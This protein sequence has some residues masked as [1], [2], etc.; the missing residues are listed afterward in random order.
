MR[1]TAAPKTIT[2]QQGCGES[3]STSES[4]S[5]RESEGERTRVRVVRDLVRKVVMWWTAAG[6][7]RSPH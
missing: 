3:E 2:P 6:K 7:T 1:W 5:E 4:E